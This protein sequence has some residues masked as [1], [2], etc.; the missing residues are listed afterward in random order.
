MLTRSCSFCTAIISLTFQGIVRIESQKVFVRSG[1]DLDN[2]D[3][4]S[5]LDADGRKEGGQEDAAGKAKF[6]IDRGEQ[7]Q[8][9]GHLKE[10]C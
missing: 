7:Q 4:V 3:L 1:I 5:G 8:S 10:L 9:E 2:D 6:N